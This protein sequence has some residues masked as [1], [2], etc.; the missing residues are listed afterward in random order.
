MKV[1]TIL[2]TRPEVIRLSRVIPQLDRYCQ[3]IVLHTGQNY[4][5]RLNEIF[6]N[7]LDIRLPDKVLDI[8]G[9]TLAEQLSKIYTGVEAY[10]REIQPDRVLILGDTNTG[11]AAIVCER[12]GIPVYHMEAGNRCYDPKVPEEKNRRVIDAISTVNL[13]YTRGSATNLLREGAHPSNVYVIGNPIGEVLTHY[14]NKIEASRV[15]EQLDLESR[16]YVVATAHREENVDDPQRLGE[17]FKALS[18]ISSTCRVIFSCH[19]R[20]RQNLHRYHIT[21]HPGITVVE[22]L[23]FFD[24]VKLEQECLVGITDS[25]TV[26]EELCLLGRPAITIRDTTERPETVECGSNT[27]VGVKSKNILSAWSRLRGVQSTWS[28]PAEYL[29]VDVSSTVVNIVLGEL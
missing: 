25:G 18:E 6:F 29:K 3:H 7:E 22:P 8:K 19:P 16:G 27:V 17:I 28:P 15:L 2:G 11:L 9:S 1:L 14:R 13:P 24:F 21:P 4:D 20:T 12:Y 10:I 5:Y 23:G 26:Q